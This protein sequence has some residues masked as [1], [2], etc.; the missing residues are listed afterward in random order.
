MELVS[1]S[2]VIL[3]CKHSCVLYL[4]YFIKTFNTQFTSRHPHRYTYSYSPL[5][6]T[7]ISTLTSSFYPLVLIFFSPVALQFLKDLGRLTYG[8]FLELFRHMVG[9]FGGVI[10]PP[11]GLYLHRTTQHR[12]TRTNIHALSGIRTHD[13]SVRAINAHAPDRTPHFPYRI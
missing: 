13:P 6:F 1:F 3:I 4:W 7:S 2:F 10:R 12:K 8:R 11:Q 5:R 9:L